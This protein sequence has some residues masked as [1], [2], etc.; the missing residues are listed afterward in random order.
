MLTNNG[1]E[2]VCFTIPKIGEQNTDIQ[3]AYCISNDGSLIAI[4]DGASTSFLPKQ[5]ATILVEHFCE[6]SQIS[7][8]KIEQNWQKW[9]QPCQEKWRQKHYI[10]AQNNPNW[11]ARPSEK[12]N[13]GSAT[14]VGLQLHSANQNGQNIWE[15]I[16]VGDSCLFQIRLEDSETPLITFPLRKS[17]DFDSTPECLNSLPETNFYHP[18]Y[19]SKNYDVNSIFLLATD[20]LAKWIFKEIENQSDY[21]QK[22]LSINTQD[23][24]AD[25][26]QHL[27][28]DKVIENDDTTLVRCKIISIPQFSSPVQFTLDKKKYEN[29]LNNNYTNELKEK[30]ESQGKQEQNEMSNYFKKIQRIQKKIEDLNII[31]YVQLLLL[32]I[33]LFGLLIIGIKTNNI[34]TIINNKFKE[35]NS[36]LKNNSS[37]SKINQVNNNLENSLIPIYSQDRSTRSTPTGYIFK[38]LSPSTN[39]DLTSTLWVHCPKSYLTDDKLQI[40]PNKGALPLYQL[41]DNPANIDLK[42]DFLGYLRSGEYLVIDKQNSQTFPDSQWAKIKVYT[43][44]QT[45]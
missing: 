45:N 15:A 31:I 3:D 30:I 44:V 42:K 35:L 4:A 39:E 5:W 9:L 11:Y 43:T 2:I 10:P 16:A 26:I 13:C 7:I 8:K 23:E 24:F 27:R 6:D 33:N 20:A 37:S 14:F 38:K 41:T 25:F 29:E 32:I 18:Q 36:T 12:K 1:N 22:L 40:P 19:I 21:W 28:S 17:T 34:E